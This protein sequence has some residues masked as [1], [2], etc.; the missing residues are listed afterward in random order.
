MGPRLPIHLVGKW[1]KFS[2]TGR[3]KCGGAPSTIKS[4][5]LGVF[6]YKKKFTVLF[7]LLHDFVVYGDYY[8]PM[9][10]IWCE[11]FSFY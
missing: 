7:N 11:M 10:N 4:T 5:R 9:R 8:T 3:A 2:L 6:I 1:S